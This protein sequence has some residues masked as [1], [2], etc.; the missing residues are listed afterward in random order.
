MSSAGI[1]FTRLLA[2]FVV[3]PGVAEVPLAKV[4]MFTSF[5]L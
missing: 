2:E 5:R 3:S 1:D 4:E